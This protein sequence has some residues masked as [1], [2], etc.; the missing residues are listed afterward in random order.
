MAE[1][2]AEK[3]KSEKHPSRSRFFLPVL[4]GSTVSLIIGFFFLGYISLTVPTPPPEDIHSLLDKKQQEREESEQLEQNVTNDDSVN[5]ITN[6]DGTFDFAEY[7][8]FSFPLP[9]VS[10]FAD[11]NG[12]VTV[13][14][15]I[16]TYATTL[17]GER[18]IEKLTTFTPKLRSAINYTMAEQ[19]YENLD[20]V[21]KR[22]A[23]E[24][25]LLEVIKPI[26]DGASPEKPSAITDLHFTKLVI[27]G[28]R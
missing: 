25:K 7:R 16:A 12:M 11:G 6:D 2:G 24:T 9:F 22:Q 27:T 18:L 28:T 26:I 20:T 10:N 13:E 4:I 14:I 5:T 8:Y 19:I 17:R 1:L 15:S 23:L 3:E 21:K